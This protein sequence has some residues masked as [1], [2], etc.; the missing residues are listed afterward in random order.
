[1]Q[2]LLTRLETDSTLDEPGAAGVGRTASVESIGPRVETHWTRVLYRDLF[3]AG[4][5]DDPSERD[6]LNRGTK[7]M[8]NSTELLQFA[9]SDE[10]AAPDVLARGDA[11]IFFLRHE[12]ASNDDAPVDPPSSREQIETWMRHTV[13]A[14]GFGGSPETVLMTKPESWALHRAARAYRAYAIGEIIAALL[15]GAVDFVR[16]VHARWLK[17]SRSRAIHAAF[18]ELDDHALRDLGLH[19]SEIGSLAAEVTGGA[20]RTR[21]LALLTRS[22]FLM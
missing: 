10:T 5:E 6:R 4:R 16:E 13:A 9:A 14:N 1:M 12:P 7:T 3:N 8:H 19:R 11:P 17:R 15:V 18:G 2:R 20:E 21:M 22:G